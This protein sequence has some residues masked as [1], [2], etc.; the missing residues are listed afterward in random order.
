MSSHNKC[1][2]GG[3]RKISAFFF[4]WKKRLIC[5]Y[6]NRKNLADPFTCRSKLTIIVID[7]IVNESK[8][9]FVLNLYHSLD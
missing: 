8:L 2:T 5:C 4:L 1:V 7:T 9:L 6:E 3:I